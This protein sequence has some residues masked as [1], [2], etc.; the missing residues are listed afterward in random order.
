[1]RPEDR[2]VALRDEYV[3]LE[4]F[5]EDIDHRCLIIE[6]LSADGNRRRP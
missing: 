4:K 2:I 1:M 3:M 6:G 5:Y